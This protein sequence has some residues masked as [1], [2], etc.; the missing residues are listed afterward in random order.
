MG[1]QVKGQHLVI[2]G[3]RNLYKFAAQTPMLLSC[4]GGKEVTST[5][6]NPIGIFHFF[7]FFVV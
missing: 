7:F 4:K 5:S 3:M 6:S 2:L 1:Y